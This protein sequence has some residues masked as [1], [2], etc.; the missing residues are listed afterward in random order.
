VKPFAGR[1]LK[2]IVNASPFARLR[3]GLKNVAHRRGFRRDV[4]PIFFMAGL[5]HT[6]EIG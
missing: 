3:Q 4:K 5:F 2:E 6:P 1:T